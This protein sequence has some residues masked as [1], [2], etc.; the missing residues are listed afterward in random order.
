MGRPIVAAEARVIGGFRRKG[1]GLTHVAG[2][3][4]F[5]KHGV[6]SR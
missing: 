2:S 1:A 5:V 3:A 6:R 4:F